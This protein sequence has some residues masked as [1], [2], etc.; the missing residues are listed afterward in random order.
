MQNK[1]TKKTE[2]RN[3]R[4][5]G[6]KITVTSSPFPI[7]V[8]FQ[9]PLAASERKVACD[10]RIASQPVPQV[11]GF[12]VPFLTSFSITNIQR[13]SDISNA[14]ISLAFGTKIPFLAPGVFS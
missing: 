3:V 11:L 2:P 6:L 9:K 12:E 4:R 7:S 1:K 14:R 10:Q 13:T 5:A 8:L